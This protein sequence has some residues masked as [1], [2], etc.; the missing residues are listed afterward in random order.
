MSVV[1]NVNFECCGQWNWETRDKKNGHAAAWENPNDG[2]ETGCTSWGIV[3][4]CVGE[5]GEGPDFMF[6]LKGKDI[7]Q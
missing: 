3:A 2:F 6:A 5:F 1:A 7:L 4:D